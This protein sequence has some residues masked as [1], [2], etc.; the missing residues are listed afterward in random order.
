MLFESLKQD[1]YQNLSIE[2]QQAVDVVAEAD[3][4]VN[5]GA[6]SYLN[7]NSK[8]FIYSQAVAT[9]LFKNIK[10]SLKSKTT[11]E[12]RAIKENMENW[13]PS[14]EV[15]NIRKQANDWRPDEE[16]LGILEQELIQVKKLNAE[17]LPP[18]L[19]VIEA[20][21][22]ASSYYCAIHSQVCNQIENDAD[23]YRTTIIGC[24]RRLLEKIERQRQNTSNYLA[25]LKKDILGSNASKQESISENNDN[26]LADWFDIYD[27]TSD[28]GAKNEADREITRQLQNKRL[29]SE[30]FDKYKVIAQAK[31]ILLEENTN[32]VMK[33]YHVH[34][35]D[36]RKIL[37]KNRDIGLVN[38]VKELGVFGLSIMSLGLATGYAHEWIF[39]AKTTRGGRF[40]QK[41][42]P[43]SLRSKL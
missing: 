37:R 31:T 39:G 8:E 1:I 34:L 28:E 14:E 42:L 18:H 7:A 26:S 32:N 13:Q 3:N 23:I 4:I 24:T 6:N 15:A 36:N 21:D 16:E 11:E 40:L 17:N 38:F 20:D 25:D 27:N 12:L 43:T 33:D 5:E 30:A 2:M 22:N 41:A 19:L 35:Y 9:V 10:K 29:K